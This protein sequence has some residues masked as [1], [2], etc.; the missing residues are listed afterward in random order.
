MH[1]ATNTTS[2]PSVGLDFTNIL[3]AAHCNHQAPTDAPLISCNGGGGGGWTGTTSV[4]APSI[5]TPCTTMYHHRGQNAPVPPHSMMTSPLISPLS[6]TTTT[7]VDNNNSTNNNGVYTTVRQADSG[8]I[9]STAIYTTPLSTVTSIPLPPPTLTSNTSTCNLGSATTSC[10]TSPP[11][12]VCRGGSAD[13]SGSIIIADTNASCGNGGSNNGGLLSRASTMHVGDLCQQ[14]CM[15]GNSAHA[16]TTSSNGAMGCIRKWTPWIIGIVVVLIGI[17]IFFL[18]YR[19]MQKRRRVVSSA[20]PGDKCKKNHGTSHVVP[21]NDTENNRVSATKRNHAVNRIINNNTTTTHPA[22][23]SLSTTH[24]LPLGKHDLPTTTTGTTV[25]PSHCNNTSCSL[26][27]TNNDGTVVHTNQTSHYATTPG[28]GIHKNMQHHCI[29]QVM[30][31]QI[32]PSL[33]TSATIPNAVPSSI[34]HPVRHCENTAHHRHTDHNHSMHG[35]SS[36]RTTHHTTTAPTSSSHRMPQPSIHMA[37][38]T[39][40]TTTMHNNPPHTSRISSSSAPFH[41]PNG[42]ASMPLSVDIDGFDHHPSIEERQQVPSTHDHYSSN[43]PRS[44]HHHHH[45]SDKR[46]TTGTHRN[47]RRSA[48]YQHNPYDSFQDN[49]SVLSCDKMSTSRQG[50]AADSGGDLQNTTLG[51]SEW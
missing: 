23:T 25:P 4:G 41:Q 8:N 10:V 2:I 37:D 5:T 15:M 13:G 36:M 21:P 24:Q 46:T 44:I 38:T 7:I 26:P 6:A 51:Q 14:G 20:N 49:Q 48:T 22:M 29:T 33:R 3:T 35:R 11:V 16:A 43:T 28:G 17:I 34:V 31:P 19:T 1:A 42:T 9:A 39:K 32:A 18:I 50:D 47:L 45:P 40:T 30:A 12:N 27:V